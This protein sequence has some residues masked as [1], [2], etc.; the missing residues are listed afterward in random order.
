MGN[1]NFKNTQFSDIIGKMGVVSHIC[2]Y[3][4]TKNYENFRIFSLPCTFLNHPNQTHC[5]VGRVVHGASCPW[6]EMSVGQNVCGAN[7]PWGELSMGRDVR[8]AKCPWG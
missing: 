6:G 8:G 7:C 1:F 3:K 5:L 2:I 4:L